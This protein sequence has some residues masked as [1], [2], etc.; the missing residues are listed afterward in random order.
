MK[1]LDKR[2]IQVLSTICCMAC[3]IVMLCTGTSYAYAWN[4]AEIVAASSTA[5]KGSIAKVTLKLSD[6]PGI[7][8]LKF[9]VGYDHDALTL[10]NVNV[11]DVFKQSE[12]TLPESYD[13]EKFIF[14]ATGNQI[15]DITANGTLVTLEFQVSDSAKASDYAISLEL[16]QCI[17]TDGK[18][19]KVKMTDGMVTVAG[20]LHSQT[21]WKVTENPACEKKGTETESCKKCGEVLGTRKIKETGHQNTEVRDAANATETKEGYTGDTYCKDCGKL[22][23]KGTVIAKVEKPKEPEKPETKPSESESESE[24]ESQTESETQMETEIQTEP[25]T[26][27]ESEQEPQPDTNTGTEEKPS[28]PVGGIIIGIVIAGLV[29]VLAVMYIKFIKRGR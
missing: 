24:S 26:E 10:K 15:S 11:G 12:L 19:V 18:D 13:K 25:E 4:S 6:N 1:R 16:V 2:R 5:E 21:E 20:C 3:M 29:G 28:S 22:L 7:W 8:G 9:Q 17:N 14:Y 23:V 27:P